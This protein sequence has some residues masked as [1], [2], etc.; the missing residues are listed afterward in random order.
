MIL[1]GT[2]AGL[3]RF[4]NDDG[5]WRNHGA[6]LEEI[7]FCDV[8][9]D[10]TRPGHVVAAAREVGIFE[11]DDAGLTWVQTAAD[12]DPWSVDIGSD[13]TAY[14][15]VRPTAI[16]HR[17]V[18]GEWGPLDLLTDQPAYGTWTFPTPPHLPNIRDIA[19]SPSDAHSLYAAV[20]V[21]GL[22]VT[23]DDGATWENH[24][25]GVHLDIHSVVTAPGDEDVIYAATGRGFYR[26]FNAGRQWEASCSGLASLY[27][28][29]IVAN[30][31]EP[32]TLVTSATQGRPRYW[33]T[34]ESG[35]E[36]VIYRSR[37]GGSQWHPV[38]HGLPEQLTGAVTG[39]A[40]DRTNPDALF[41]V[42]AD[43]QVLGSDSFGDDWFLV[44]NGLPP[45]NAVAV[46]PD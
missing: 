33:R 6:A 28:V 24:R 17:T 44:A 11:S 5:G 32:H 42:V 39:L 36:S 16:Y 31:S 25:E 29:P 20:E 46:V 23:T 8:A 37:D 22:L 7:G 13:G 30:V 35:A 2:Q 14:A 21:G 26:S 43:G 27:L 18:G 19:F 4:S 41:A 45:A 1:V 34:R 10:P 38:M 15:G 3:F 40:V 12:L 9:S